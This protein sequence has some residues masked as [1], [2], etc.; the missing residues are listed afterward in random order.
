[1]TRG[2]VALFSCLAAFGSAPLLAQGV[3][4]PGLRVE[5]VAQGLSAPTAMA[6]LGLSGEILV[7]Q[8]DGNVRH[9]GGNF[10]GQ[11]VL[12]L[13]VNTAGE[14]GLLGMAA[15]PG[16]NLTVSQFVY[17]YYTESSTGADTSDPAALLGNRVYRYTW[18]TSPSPALVDPRLIL[19]LPGAPGPDHNGGVL[20]FGPDDALY[21]VVGDLDRNG[22]LQ[23][24][25][26]GG[27]PDDTGVVFR[28]DT[29]GNATTSTAAIRPRPRACRSVG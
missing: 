28:V 6:F 4:D 9:F 10:T 23:N 19:D 20:A 16:F 26:P 5:I 14:R 27:D 25:S 2:R 13:P 24:N 17:L 3:A 1:M 8:R 29:S 15:D 18:N 12:D 7:A 22:K 21:V 11:T